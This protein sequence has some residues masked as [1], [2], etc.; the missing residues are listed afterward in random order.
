[1][2]YPSLGIS[3]TGA[4]DSATTDRQLDRATNGAARLR[5]FYTTAKRTFKFSHPALNATDL[6]TFEAFYAANVDNSFDFTWP[7]DNTTYT[8]VFS[9][10]PSRKVYS[11]GRTEVSVELAEV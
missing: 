7:L 8:A 2:A 9:A 5:V 10:E 1:M 6:G 11:F 4:S 3:A